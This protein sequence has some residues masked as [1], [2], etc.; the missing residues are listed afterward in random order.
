MVDLISQGAE[1]EALVET[2]Q[3]EQLEHFAALLPR[4]PA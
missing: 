4:W 1:S 3:A 2:G